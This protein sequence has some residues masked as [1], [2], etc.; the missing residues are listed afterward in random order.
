MKKSLWNLLN[1]FIIFMVLIGIFPLVFTGVTS[2]RVSRDALRQNAAD[3]IYEVVSNQTDYLDLQVKQIESLM[4]N[5]TG[6]ETIINSLSAEEDTQSAYTK[7]AT[8]AQVGYI[9]NNY[10]S[11]EG[12][13]SIDIFSTGGEH[14]HIGDTLNISAIDWEIEEKIFQTVLDS[15]NE[16]VWLGVVDNVNLNSGFQE[17][18]SAASVLYQI[19]SDTFELEPIGLLIINFSTEYFYDYLSQVN[20]GENSF[21]VVLDGKGEFIYHPDTQKIGTAP[22]PNLLENVVDVSGSFEIEIDE[23]S[24]FVIYDHLEMNDWLIISCVPVENLVIGDE[25]VQRAVVTSIIFLIILI[26]LAGVLVSRRVV[27]PIREITSR[28]RSAQTEDDDWYQKKMPVINQTDE[29]GELTQWFNV[30]VDNLVAK[31]QTEVALQERTAELEETNRQLTIEIE[32]RKKAEDEVL[33]LNATLEQR[34]EKRTEQL[35]E[36]VRELEAFSYSVSHDLRAPLRAIKGFSDILQEDF[37]T[38]FDEEINEYLMLISSAGQKMDDLINALL[39]LS[40]LGQNQLEFEELCVGEVAEQIFWEMAQQESGRDF[41]AVFHP[42]EPMLVDKNLLTIMLTNLISNSIK[43][44]RNREVA[45]IEF[46]MV[47][48][49]GEEY[50]YLKDNG[51][52]F[53]MR[54]ADKL[55]GTF[56]RLHDDTYEG[57]GIGLAIVKR[58][59]ARHDG[60]IFAESKKGEGAIFY[61]SMRAFEV[62]E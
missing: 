7:L 47:E 49:D 42:C 22:E 39:L 10:S 35:E 20:L 19:S 59:I 29:I 45:E 40:R 6:Q 13:V 38:E 28:F 27:T 15:G 33:A 23:R 51:V 4:H 9:L 41:E 3:Y 36:A 1:K 2:Y 21:L 50:Y 11:L 44:T 56:Q 53:D 12:L 16:I 62:E 61:F 57:M 31:Q 34:V 52:G 55:F 24:V 8:H 54:F 37:G 46:G 30:F 43:F 60:V 17:V 14:Y 26:G 58:I 18:V 5:I 32:E 25:I 48:K